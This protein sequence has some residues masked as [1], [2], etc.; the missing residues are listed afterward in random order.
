MTRRSGSN[1]AQ[2]KSLETQGRKK[3]KALSEVPEHDQISF[4]VASKSHPAGAPQHGL[5]WVSGYL[6]WVSPKFLG[7]EDLTELRR[8]LSGPSLVT[9][10]SP[11]RNRALQLKTHT[12]TNAQRHT[13]VHVRQNKGG[14]KNIEFLTYCLL[15]QT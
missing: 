2:S 7:K 13:C 4:L 15:S 11:K 1:T 8:E 5:G 6:G 9:I 14:K 12:H 10:C 3:E